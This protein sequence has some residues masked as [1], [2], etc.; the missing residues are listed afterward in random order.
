MR[1][2]QT[3]EGP[4]WFEFTVDTDTLTISWDGMVQGERGPFE[5][6]PDLRAAWPAVVAAVCA[7]FGDVDDFTTHDQP[8]VPMD[9][10]RVR[11]RTARRAAVHRD[12]SAWDALYA[13]ARAAVADPSVSAHVRAQLSSH[14]RADPSPDRLADSLRFV[15]GLQRTPAENIPVG[16]SKRGGL[17]DLPP[18]HPWPRV[19]GA[20][21]AL[22]LQLDLSE[23]AAV[24]VTGSIP[25]QGVFQL[26]ATA[27]GHGTVRLHA[28]RDDLERHPPVSPPPYLAEWFDQEHALTPVP[29]FYCALGTDI[30][31]PEAVSRALPAD[32]R[33]RL[34]ALLGGGPSD[35]FA[36]DRVLG[37]DPVDWQSMGGSH[38]AAPLF[39]QVCFQDGHV[40]VGWDLADRQAGIVDDI[41]V[42][43]RGT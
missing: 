21:T 43:Y 7:P 22:L 9:L 23:L 30:S 6:W 25:S 12:T 41:D 28:S 4:S 1:L 19:N 3:F 31:S 26:F 20:P 33:A 37:G 39:C 27:H 14:H 16:G 18:D 40:S 38:L 24:D 15:L 17:P 11:A 42:G 5:S 2:T 36:E 8:S 34:A 13:Q 10:D 35:A 29:G 32:T